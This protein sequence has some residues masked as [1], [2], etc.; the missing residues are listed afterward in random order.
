LETKDSSFKLA[1][2]SVVSS[3][4]VK[5]LIHFFTISISFIEHAVSE[6]DLDIEGDVRTYL[7]SFHQLFPRQ[8]KESLQ[9]AINRSQGIAIFELGERS[10]TFIAITLALWW[11]APF[12]AII[13]GI[14]LSFSRIFFTF[15]IPILPVALVIDAIISILRTRTDLE[16]LQLVESIPGHQNHFIP[17]WYC[18]GFPVSQR[19]SL[20]FPEPR[21]NQL[22]Q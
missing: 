20:K 15:I 16:I 19:N 1:Q 7:A 21:L 14:K 22:E 3:S 12:V 6:K 4:C 8:A 11:I 13:R 2:V 18:V 10:W 5:F 9:E 17:I